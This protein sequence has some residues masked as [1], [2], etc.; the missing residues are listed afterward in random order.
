MDAVVSLLVAYAVGCISFASLVG[1]LRGVDVRA[2]GSGNPGATNVGRVLGKGWGALVLLLDLAKGA[3]P[4]WLMTAPLAEAP[5]LLTDP[6]GRAAL[7]GA[8]TLGHVYP[9]TAGFRGGKGVATFLGGCLVLEPLSALGAVALHLLVKRALGMVSIA[10]LVLVWAVPLGRLVVDATG[11]TPSD[12]VVIMAAL[13]A[14]ITVRHKDNLARI[15]AGAEYRYD[16]PSTRN[17]DERKS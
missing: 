15:R 16:E 17:D 8:A 2:H 12:G 5:A 14:V 1:R 9:V 10:S 3:V 4:A 11:G 13:A 6:A 7:V